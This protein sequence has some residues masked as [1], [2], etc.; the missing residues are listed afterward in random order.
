MTLTT[1]SRSFA[2]HVTTAR[3][4]AVVTDVVDKPRI[5]SAAKVV[6]EAQLAEIAK[7][8]RAIKAPRTGYKRDFNIDTT[9]RIIAAIEYLTKH[10]PGLFVPVTLLYW[11]CMPGTHALQAS[12]SDVLLFASRVS[13]CKRKMLAQLGRTFMVRGG[14]RQRAGYIRGYVSREEHAQ[15]ELPRA[16]RSAE[17]AIEH[18]EQVKDAVGNPDTLK[19]SATFTDEQKSDARAQIKRALTLIS[20]YKALP[21]APE[22]K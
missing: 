14:T 5:R 19:V 22:K 8:T 15:N 12:N 6:N 18:V 16:V 9:E 4:G 1:Q 11:M 10:H 13:R 3:G 17:R 21:P 2:E 7:V 20:A